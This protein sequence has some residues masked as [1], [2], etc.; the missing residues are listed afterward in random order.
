MQTSAKRVAGLYSDSD[1]F[2]PFVTQS[3]AVTQ[4]RLLQCVRVSRW[5]TLLK[6]DTPWGSTQNLQGVL[7]FQVAILSHNTRENIPSYTPAQK[8]LISLHQF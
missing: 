2:S 5:P 4:Y 6:S 3:L 8:V 7:L 1:T